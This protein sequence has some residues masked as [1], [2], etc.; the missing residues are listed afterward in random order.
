M[1]DSGGRCCSAV[2][3]CWPDARNQPRRRETHP[4]PTPPPPPSGIPGL[5]GGPPFGE[6]L[7]T[8]REMQGLTIEQLAEVSQIAP[9]ALRAMESGAGAAPPANAA[10]ALA[11]AFRLGKHDRQLFLLSATLQSPALRGWM[12]ALS[13]AP[14]PPAKPAK[15]ALPAAILAFLI[16]DVRGYTHF[17]QDYGDEAAAR[18][19]T[20]F[21]DIC[22]AGAEHWNGR[23]IEL[24]G[25]EALVVF[26]SVRQAVRAA[27]DLQVR[28]AEASA[29]QPDLPL[30][31]GIGVD[32][33]EAIPVEEG[34]RGAALNRAA[35]LCSQAGAGEVLVSAGLIYVA[36]GVEGAAFL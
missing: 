34:Y 25:D 21:A 30:P 31:V 4:M 12:G 7:R 10:E 36:P 19:A 17:T 27:L 1:A 8:Y 28:F 23:L 15:S 33:G 29:A 9:S 6:L 26:A 11:D 14:Q 20:R 13:G 16:A 24:R 2:V 22:R 35:R 18:L 3:P 5:P 32:V